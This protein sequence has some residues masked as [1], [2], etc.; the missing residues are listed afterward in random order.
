MIT[1]ANLFCLWNPASSSTK[2][3]LVVIK[4]SSSVFVLSHNETADQNTVSSIM[5]VLKRLIIVSPGPTITNFSKIVQLKH[6]IYSK[7]CSDWPRHMV[8][9]FEHKFCSRTPNFCNNKSWSNSHKTFVT[10]SPDL[11]AIK[12]LSISFYLY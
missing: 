4:L 11:I 8:I 9:L 7:Q 2:C 3:G 10:I 6:W 1:N 12:L 5:F